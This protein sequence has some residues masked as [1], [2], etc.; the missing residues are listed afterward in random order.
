[1]FWFYIWRISSL[2][3]YSRCEQFYLFEIEPGN[4]LN[5]GLLEV[6]IQMVTYRH[7]LWAT[8]RCL[9]CFKNHKND[10]YRFRWSSFNTEECWFLVCNNGL[11]L[12]SGAC[13]RSS[14]VLDGAGLVLCGAVYNTGVKPGPSGCRVWSANCLGNA[15]SLIPWTRHPGESTIS[16]SRV[17]SIVIVS[18]V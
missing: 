11:E 9:L 10:V 14:L 18:S 13:Q 1:M 12:K 5:L 2:E 4:I 6:G 15:P 7:R 17:T 8:A 3:K 16:S